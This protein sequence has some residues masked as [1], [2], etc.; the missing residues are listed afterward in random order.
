[1]F[2]RDLIA[3]TLIMIATLT[4]SASSQETEAVAQT[5]VHVGGYVKRLSNIS[6]NDGSF[7]V[8]MWIWLR[9]LGADLDPANSFE[10]EKGHITDLQVQSEKLNNKVNYSKMRVRATIHH[11][12]DAHRFPLDEHF[13]QIIVKFPLKNVSDIS[14]ISDRNIEMDP[15]IS[16]QG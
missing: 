7:D 3:I 12:F 13:L 14:Y 15:S 8:D 2:I 16:L 6:E 9:W 10:I 5:E 1:M 4:S 11:D